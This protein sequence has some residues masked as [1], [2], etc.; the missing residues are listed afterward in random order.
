MNRL[1]AQ[2]LGPEGVPV[3]LGRLVFDHD[4]GV[5]VGQLVDDVLELLA[6]LEVVERL[7]ALLRDGDAARPP[8]SLG[9]GAAKSPPRLDGGTKAVVG[10]VRRM[11]AYPDLLCT[12]SLVSSTP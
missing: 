3:V 5:V 12:R 4:L 7:D 11:D 2:Q 6:E 10:V 1:G 8:V 9:F